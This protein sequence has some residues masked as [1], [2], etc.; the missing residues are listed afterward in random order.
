MRIFK[1]VLLTLIRLAFVGVLKAVLFVYILFHP[2]G[3]LG[4]LTRGRRTGDT[5]SN[6]VEKVAQ[7]SDEFIP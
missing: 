5:F 6:A 7:T 1:F 2:D 4:A 3:P